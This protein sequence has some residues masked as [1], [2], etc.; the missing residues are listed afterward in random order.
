MAGKSAGFLYRYAVFEHMRQ[1]L[2]SLGIPTFQIGIAAIDSQR[3]L[4]L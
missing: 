4:D 1:I 3:G 2:T